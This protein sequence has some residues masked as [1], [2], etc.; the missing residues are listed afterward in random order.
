MHHTGMVH[1]ALLYSLRSLSQL[2]VIDAFSYAWEVS[3]RQWAR[4]C[5][6]SLPYIYIISYKLYGVN[7]FV[8]RFYEN[9]FTR[10]VCRSM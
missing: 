3:F 6:S 8:K 2:N 1:W 10:P 9:A 7:T 5:K 4:E